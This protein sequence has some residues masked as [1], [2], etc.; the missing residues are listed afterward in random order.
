MKRIMVIGVSAGVGKTTFA[1][2]LGEALQIKVHH[3][4]KLYWKP[5]WVE[6]PFEDFA[7]AQS[8]LFKRSS[9]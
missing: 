9:G 7:A 2:E 3:L 6:T 4:D 8:K 5:G 1:R